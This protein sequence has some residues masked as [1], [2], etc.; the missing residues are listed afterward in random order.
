MMAVYSVK[1]VSSLVSIYLSFYNS[2]FYFAFLLSITFYDMSVVSL[3]EVDQL[4]G[5]RFCSHFFTAVCCHSFSS[6]DDDD[7]NH[8]IASVIDIKL[9]IWL[10]SV[11][12]MEMVFAL[13]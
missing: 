7:V 2:S 5:S 13:E 3:V 6:T 1:Y 10:Q 12:C 4:R 11:R 9:V 8:F